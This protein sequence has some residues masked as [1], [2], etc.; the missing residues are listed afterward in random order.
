MSFTNPYRVHN[1]IGEHVSDASAT[2]F[3]QQQRWDSNGDGTGTIQGGMIFYDSVL[4]KLRYAAGS[5]W[6]DISTPENPL[7]MKYDYIVSSSAGFDTAFD[8]SGTYAGKSIYI[9]PG[10]YTISASKTFYI[11]SGMKVDWGSRGGGSVA[12]GSSNVY[13]VMGSGS[14]FMSKDS[15]DANNAYMSFAGRVDRTNSMTVANPERLVV[16]TGAAAPAA[17]TF[18][19]NIMSGTNPSVAVNGQRYL[20]ASRDS[21]TQLSYVA[22]QNNRDGLNTSVGPILYTCFSD[23]VAGV[24]MVGSVY[25]TSSDTPGDSAPYFSLTG[26]DHD[27]SGLRMRFDTTRGYEAGSCLARFRVVR[28]R[29]GPLMA[30]NATKAI[31]TFSGAGTYY[32]PL[33]L[34]AGSQNSKFEMIRISNIKFT[35]NVAARAGVFYMI[36]ARLMSR[37]DVTVDLTLNENI[38]GTG[39]GCT[40]QGVDYQFAHRSTLRGVYIQNSATTTDTATVSTSS[41]G[42]LTAEFAST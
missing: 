10:N 38:T 33:F 39:G 20:L 7:M 41:S 2:S 18:P 6:A 12:S 4:G 21:N 1:Y 22:S 30:A 31:S 25:F 32:L 29:I 8:I 34:I 3:V 14:R 13:I 27:L 42:M 11:H 16:D 35:N 28:S 36:D 9:T 23:D 26:Y 24:T 17:A 15:M 19:A 5:S 37:C 40:N